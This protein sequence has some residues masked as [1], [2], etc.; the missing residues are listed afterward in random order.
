MG[1][2]R[3][4]T[5]GWRYPQWRGDFYPRGL[6]QRLELEFLSRTMNTVEVNGSFYG[7][8]KPSDYHS[9]HARTPDDFLFAV[10]GH[11]EITHLRRLRDVGGAVAEFFAS[12][13][14]DLGHKLGP[15]LWQLPPTL[16]YRPERL[17]AFLDH[18]PGPPVRHAL[19]VRHAGYLVPELVELLTARG[20]AL[21]VAESAGRFPQPEVLTADF[22]YVRLHGDEELYVSGYSD[23]ALDRWAAKVRAWSRERDVYVYFDNTMHGA[24]PHDAR[25][26]AARLA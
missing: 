11:K 6:Q 14:L 10:K 9:W 13:V 23:E 8:R 20:V 19:E 5:S 2:I 26:L 15:V 18:L 25:A 22:A 17:A 21:V 16:P 24:A 3:I 1:E 7:L 12:G 4:G